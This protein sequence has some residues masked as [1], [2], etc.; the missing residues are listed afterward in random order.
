MFFVV[1]TIKVNR[2]YMVIKKRDVALVVQNDIRRT[3]F[4][5]ETGSLPFVILI[6]M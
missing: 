6:R 3:L 2:Y 5:N 1:V 4:H